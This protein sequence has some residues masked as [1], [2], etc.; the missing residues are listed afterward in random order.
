MTS[1]S[2]SPDEMFSKARE[3]WDLDRLYRDLAAVKQ[4]PLTPGEKEYLR[5]LLLG[6]GPKDIATT[7]HRS[8]NGVGVALSHLYQLM[9]HLPN[10]PP[11]RVRASRIPHL[12]EQARYRRSGSVVPHNVATPECYVD[13][14]PIENNCYET[15]L[16]P[17]SLI[18]IKAPQ[19]MGKTLLLSKILNQAEQKHYRTVKLSFRLLDRA[20]FT[21]LDAFLQVFCRYVGH[22]LGI[23]DRVADFWTQTFG[24]KINCKVYFEEYLLANIHSPLVLGLDDVD[25]VFQ[26]NEIATDFLGL[27]RAWYE[28]G[29]NREIWQKL[30]LILVHSTEVYVPLDS[31]QSPF[32]VGWAVDLPEFEPEQVWKLALLRK[33]VDWQADHIEQLIQLVGG[34]PYLVQVALNSMVQ[35]RLTLD[36]LIQL[37]PTESGPFAAHLRRHLLCLEKHPDLAEAMTNIVVASEPTYLNTT[38]AFQLQSM[39]LV[40]L[41]GNRVRIRNDLYRQYFR[42]RLIQEN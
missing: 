33:F 9:S 14:P 31:N 18:R 16:Q 35:Q 4:E 25:L 21:N 6:H 7:M 15:I 24:S 26:Y 32:N 10:L 40:H 11:E 39:G 20:I 22:T 42:D 29:R 17:G 36:Q 8:A 23:P 38:Q 1:S 37:A 19:Q 5:A 3:L 12:L 34:H 41:E 2:D 13:R 27:L 28:E 30:R